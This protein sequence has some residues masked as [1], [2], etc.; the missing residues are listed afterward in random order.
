MPHPAALEE[1]LPVIGGQDDQGVVVEAVALEP[2][3]EGGE[4]AVGER[5][6]RVVAVEQEIAIRVVELLQQAPEI[7]DGMVLRS[8]PS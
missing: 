2:F 1:L 5:D 7:D 6:L 4:V 8:G 3:E